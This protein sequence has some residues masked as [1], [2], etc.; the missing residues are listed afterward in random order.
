MKHIILQLLLL[1]FL[2]WESYGQIVPTTQNKREQFSTNYFPLENSE[3]TILIIFD[4][5]QPHLNIREDSTKG[6]DEYFRYLQFSKGYGPGFN[7]CINLT[8]FHRAGPPFGHEEFKMIKKGLGNYKKI[9]EKEMEFG[10][11]FGN[12]SKLMHHTLILVE[13]KDWNSNEK[14]IRGIQVSLRTSGSCDDV[15]DL[16]EQDSTP[17]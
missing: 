13:E 17:K 7:E 1:T 5:E 10:Y 9:S 8:F 6:G 14:K 4:V 16:T 12:D 3:D 15:I 11:W 2:Y